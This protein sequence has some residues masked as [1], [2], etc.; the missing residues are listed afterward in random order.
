M[1][2][3]EQKNSFAYQNNFCLDRYKIKVKYV[4]IYIKYVYIDI[5]F[6]IYR[7]LFWLMSLKTV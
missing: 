6:Q 7:K 2:H 5:L 3:K 4:E 1:K